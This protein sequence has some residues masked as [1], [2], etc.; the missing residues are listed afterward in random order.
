MTSFAGQGIEC[1]SN[2]TGTP[3]QRDYCTDAAVTPEP[4]TLLLLGSGL[5]GM[6]G[7]GFVR[8]KRE[9]SN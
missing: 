8:R 6:S 4:M 5:A 3:K 7:F 1:G 2:D 9:D